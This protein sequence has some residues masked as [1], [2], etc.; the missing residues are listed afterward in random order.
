[1]PLTTR[2]TFL[3]WL[4]ALPPATLLTRKKLELAGA[5]LD[6]VIL[7]AMA[8]AALPSELGSAGVSRVVD[9]FQRWLAEY[10]P[11]AELVHGYGTSTIRHTPAD[12]G[13]RWRSQLTALDAEARTRHRRSFAELSL[14][15]RRALIRGVLA[16]H[17]SATLPSVAESRHVGLALLSFYYASP[18]ATD[19]CYRAAIRRTGCRPLADAPQPPARLDEGRR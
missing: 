9:G 18:A 6:A 12:P 16:E 11:G 19:L 15:E 2:R 8:E 1:M 13:S 3:S 5:P 17:Q 4:A 14:A 10:R 7:R